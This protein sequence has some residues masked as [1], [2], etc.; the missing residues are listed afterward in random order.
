MAHA[1][2]PAGA[3]AEIESL[4]GTW[5]LISATTDGQPADP[6]ALNNVRVVIRDGHHSVYFGEQVVAK[7]IAFTIDPTREPKHTT[8]TLPDGSRIKGIYALDGDTLTSCVAP[9]GQ[10]RPVEFASK[11]GSGHTLRVFKRILE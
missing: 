3:P 4:E 5:Q 10:E 1:E 2:Q 8:D 7:E 9:S 11:P 6:E